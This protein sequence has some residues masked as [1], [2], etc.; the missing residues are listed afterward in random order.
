MRVWQSWVQILAPPLKPFDLVAIYL[1]PVI[2][3]LLRDKL[4]KIMPTL[5]GTLYEVKRGFQTCL[6]QSTQ[7]D[8]I[9]TAP[10][11]PEKYLLVSFIR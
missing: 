11:G 10:R 2:L 3:S 7:R 4:E 9:F 6:A 8:S 1:T 5:L